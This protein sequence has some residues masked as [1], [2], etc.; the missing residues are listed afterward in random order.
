MAPNA[1]KI[2]GAGS[3]GTGATIFQ[4]DRPAPFPTMMIARAS[5]NG[6]IDISGIWWKGFQN[7]SNDD[8]DASGLW[9]QTSKNF[10]IHHCKFTDF[11][12]SAI[13]VGQPYTYP[14][15]RGVIDHNLIDD[16]Y[17]LTYGGVWGYGIIMYGPIGIDIPWTSDVDNI[18]N[19]LGKYETI[20]DSIPVAYVEDNTFR[21]L[22]HNP[23]ASQGGWFVSRH[24]WYD[25]GSYVYAVCCHAGS[26]GMEVYDN[27]IDATNYG[28]AWEKR[29]IAFRGG[30]GVAF[31]NTIINA[32]SGVRFVWEGTSNPQKEPHN[33]WLWN[34]TLQN[35]PQYIENLAGLVENVDY[36]LYQKQGY[37]SYQYPHWLVTD[38][39]QSTPKTQL[40]NAGTYRVG[41]P[42][43][44]AVG[45]KN[46]QLSHWQETQI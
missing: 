46:Y 3:E 2:A 23:D 6:P 14:Q 1:V 12:S 10:R 21:R 28:P 20:P 34:N 39:P 7:Q 33:I 32:D 37:V 8:L 17:K 16:P 11:A 36:F 31:N 35:T 5:D 19:F 27:V 43:T 26:R 38:I 45:G 22:R 42:K 25:G 18:D 4:T 24:N 41:T 29:A 9:M 15:A 13:T 40:L 30:G 44:L